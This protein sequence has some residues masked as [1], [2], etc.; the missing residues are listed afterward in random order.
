MHNMKTELK[1][2]ISEVMEL[3]GSYIQMGRKVIIDNE[4]TYMR[5]LQFKATTD[6]VVA[7]DKY[8]RLR[9]LSK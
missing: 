7:V 5:S 2:E 1:V 4:I 9:Y 3:V 8:Y 6:N